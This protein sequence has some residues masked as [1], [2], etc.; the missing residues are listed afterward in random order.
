MIRL[1][2]GAPM[3]A[4]VIVFA[5]GCTT[6][7]AGARSDDRAPEPAGGGGPAAGADTVA[8]RPPVASP[9]VDSIAET[10]VFTPTTQE[11][12]V[13]AVRARRLLVDIGRVDARVR[14]PGSREIDSVRFAAYREAVERRSHVRRG[15][16]FRLRG[17]W[18]A[19]DA[20]V[21]GF[22]WWTGRIVATLTLPP[23][24][25]S[26]ARRGGDSLVVSAQRTT[27]ITPAV[28]DSCARD[29][30]DTLLVQRAD[31]LRDSLRIALI[32]DSTRFPPRVRGEIRSTS[33]RVLGCFG[34]SRILIVA[35]VRTPRYE[36]LAQRAFLV[37]SAG[38]PRALRITDFRFRAHDPIAAFDADG[39]GVHDLAAR[40]YGEAAGA[41]TILRLV[42]G[43]RLERLSGGFAWEG[44]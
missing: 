30:V 6:P 15:D 38:K 9:L 40:G 18:G 21:S 17:P 1:L 8:A 7:D 12:F 2:R 27:I 32:A 23:R 26:L 28:T 14:K 35:S 13:G 34:A 19:D 39:D 24:V 25:D 11:W 22:D 36:F 20:I 43:R 29:S 44:M 33:A 41:T 31:S 10:L 3:L 4:A 37:D 5:A 16:L 42:D